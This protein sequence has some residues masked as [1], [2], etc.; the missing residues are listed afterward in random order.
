MIKASQAFYIGEGCLRLPGFDECT[1]V[2]VYVPIGVSAK[3]VVEVKVLTGGY[4]IQSI[5]MGMFMVFLT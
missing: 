4:F 1:S 3:N 2:Y 5:K